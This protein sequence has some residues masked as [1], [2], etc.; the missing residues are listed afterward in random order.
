MVA[1][2]WRA[3]HSRRHRAQEKLAPASSP[4]AGRCRAAPVGRE[5]NGTGRLRSYRRQS[6]RSRRSRSAFTTDHW[7]PPLHH[8]NSYAPIVYPP[9]AGRAAPLMSLLTMLSGRPAPIAGLP[10]ATRKSSPPTFTNCGS[11]LLR[12]AERVAPEPVLA[13]APNE[14]LLDTVAFVRPPVS[15]HTPAVVGW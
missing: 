10:A 15:S 13:T 3:L 11:V 4:R 14:M 7:R 5:I 2:L 1:D 6:A 12:L 8:L 9:V